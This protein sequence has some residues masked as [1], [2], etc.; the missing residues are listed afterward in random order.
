MFTYV[1]MHVCTMFKCGSI[2]VYVCICTHLH[3][4]MIRDIWIGYICIIQDKEN[5]I[6]HDDLGRDIATVQAL[7][8]K[9]ETF[10]HELEALGNQ[11]L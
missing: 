3:I 9:H 7:Q 10:E 8:R 2:C 1:F 5:S 11:V 6:R 4:C